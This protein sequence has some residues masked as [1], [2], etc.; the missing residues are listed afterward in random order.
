MSRGRAGTLLAGAALVLA[1]TV[2]WAV[3]TPSPS[4]PNDEAPVRLTVTSLLPRAPAPGQAFEVIGRLTNV[5]TQ[6]ARGVRVQ[7][8]VGDRISTRS[9][10]ADADRDRPPTSR[11]VTGTTSVDLDPGQGASFDLRTTVDRLE[12]GDAGVYPLDI[13]ATGRFGDSPRARLGNAPTWVPWMAGHQVAPTRVAVLWPLVDEPHRGA[14]DALLDD[15]LAGELAP[16]GRLA[17]LLAAGAAAA[18]G[19]CDG[20]PRPPDGVTVSAPPASLASRCEPAPVTFAVDPELLQTVQA[21]TAPYQVHGRGKPVQGT[22]TADA[23][24]WLEGLRTVAAGSAVLALPY[25]DP[26]VP[27][28]ARDARGRY[29]V[30]LARTLG[31]QVVS[32][33]LGRVPLSS[34]AWPPAGPVPTGAQE[35]LAVN[36]TRAIVLDPTAFPDPQDDPGRTPGARTSL[37]VPN[38]G[39][40]IVGL[41]PDPGLSGLVTGASARDLGQRLAEQRWIAET[42]IIAAEAPSLSRT[43][44]VVPDRR[45]DVVSG[46]AAPSL[47]DIGRLPW[48]CPVQLDDVASGSERCAR[49]TPSPEPPPTDRGDPRTATAGQLSPQFL[50]G[51]AHDRDRAAQLTE[52]VLA[53]RDPGTSVLKA[54][55]RRAVARAESSAWRSDPAGGRQVSQLLRASVD[56]LLG[57]LSVHGAPLTLTSSKGTLSVSVDN[58]LDVPVA[59]AVQFTS[60]TAALSTSRTPVRL[61][62]PHA[63]AQLSVRATARTSGRFEVVAQLLDRDGSGF[64]NPATIEVRSTQYGRLALALT[65]IGAGVLLVAAGVRI[66]RRALRRDRGG[67]V[68]A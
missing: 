57:G 14:D 58:N 2:T 54:Q 49:E 52:S 31:T 34:T 10:L 40:P 15:R 42:A 50:A 6:P 29:D 53:P 38:T 64:G 48:L 60:R 66:V 45:G 20:T 41:V 51:I 67:E 16:T 18:Q 7:L 39:T 19:Q 12:L 32:D 44:L 33:L 25:A 11:R 13:E 61:I 5:G 56:R 9:G 27:A 46:A 63:S 65:A 37:P 36:G 23:K 24:T 62:P 43:L 55:L 59:C 4:P 3:P 47:L 1:P 35:T 21:M 28:L 68:P 30:S 26:D 22:G 8:R 17:H